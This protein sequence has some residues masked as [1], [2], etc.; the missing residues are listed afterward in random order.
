MI[1]R[2]SQSTLFI[3][4]W[5]LSYDCPLAQKYV[6]ILQIEDREGDIYQQLKGAQSKKTDKCEHL[7]SESVIYN[8]FTDGQNKNEDPF[9]YG[10]FRKIFLLF[11]S[12]H[13]QHIDST[14]QRFCNKCHI[15][16][17]SFSCSRLFSG[18]LLLELL[19]QTI[20]A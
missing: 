10:E 4:D 19:L 3:F 12:S 16:Y 1:G 20:T 11:K 8:I 13:H 7:G 2:V 6:Y 9:V 15:D 14:Y 5:L 17:V 18:V